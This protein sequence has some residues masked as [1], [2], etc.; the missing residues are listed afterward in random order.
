MVM[1]GM[2]FGT[3]EVMIR[4]ICLSEGQTRAD[5]KATHILLSGGMAGYMHWVPFFPLDTLKSKI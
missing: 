1:S 5:L 4:Y 2:Y 3:Y